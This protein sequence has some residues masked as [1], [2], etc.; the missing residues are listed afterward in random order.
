[1]GENSPGCLDPMHQSWGRDLRVDKVI[2]LQ[3]EGVIFVEEGLS[4]SR[5]NPISST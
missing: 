5:H 1:M 2:D 4:S 3:N